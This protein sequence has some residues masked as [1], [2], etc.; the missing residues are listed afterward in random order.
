MS[1]TRLLSP[2]SPSPCTLPVHFS[3]LNLAH[4]IEVERA[5]LLS[6]VIEKIERAPVGEEYYENASISYTVK[7]SEELYSRL[8]KAGA[9]APV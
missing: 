1:L 5:H 2:R 7:K 6:D 4:G 9:W 3:R 8:E